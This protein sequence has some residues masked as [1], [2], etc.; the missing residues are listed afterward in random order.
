MKIT[1]LATLCLFLL[2]LRRTGGGNVGIPQD[3]EIDIHDAPPGAGDADDVLD[4]EEGEE[5]GGSEDFSS[6]MWS[7]DVGTLHGPILKG[8][9]TSCVPG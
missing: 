6:R 7:D 4:A 3:D 1:L 9:L 8:A 5:P 2:I